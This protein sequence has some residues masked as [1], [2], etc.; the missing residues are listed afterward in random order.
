MRKISEDIF[1]SFF[2]VYALTDFLSVQ[3]GADKIKQPRVAVVPNLSFSTFADDSISV[4]RFRR[5]FLARCLA[6]FVSVLLLSASFLRYKVPF[7]SPTLIGTLHEIDMNVASPA[8]WVGLNPSPFWPIH[9][10]Y[11]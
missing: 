7:T 6:Y 11:A 1:D 5:D 8:T 10:R 4:E 9:F 3:F 2:F